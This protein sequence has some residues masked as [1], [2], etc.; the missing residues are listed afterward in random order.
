MFEIAKISDENPMYCSLVVETTEDKATLY[1]ATQNPEM[2][3][4]DFINQELD[5]TDVYMEQVEFEDEDTGEIRKGIRTVFFTPEGKGV[6]AV[7]N[8]IARSLYGIFRIFGTPDQWGGQIM[9]VMV[10][11]KET[12]R[13]RTFKLE[14]IS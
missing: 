8:G 13:G 7:S 11:Q 2:K 9:R 6:M 1:N 3:V 14:V 4:S 12:A 5:F 10:R